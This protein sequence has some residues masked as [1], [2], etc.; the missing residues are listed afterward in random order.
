M[1]DGYEEKADKENGKKEEIRKAVP[2]T[3]A[4]EAGRRVVTPEASSR[5]TTEVE[6]GALGGA[7]YVIPGVKYQLQNSDGTF[8]NLSADYQ[9]KLGDANRL[10]V[11]PRTGDSPLPVSQ[12]YTGQ[13]RFSVGKKWS[14][15]EQNS[16]TTHSL[17]VEG[18]VGLQ[19]PMMPLGYTTGGE[20]G[21]SGQP[22]IGGGVGGFA[23]VENTNLETGATKGL[24]GGIMA[25]GGTQGVNI[26][27][28]IGAHASSAQI[29]PK[30]GRPLDNT[31][32]GNIN[33]F[34]GANGLNQGIGVTGTVQAGQ[35]FTTGPADDHRK[36]LLRESVSQAAALGGVT[37]PS[38]RTGASA[39]A[40]VTAKMNENGDTKN[41]GAQFT[42][43]RAQV[44]HAHLAAGTSLAHGRVSLERDVSGG[45]RKMT[46]K[47]RIATVGVYAEGFAA[48]VGPVAIP[49]TV[50]GG[51]TYTQANLDPYFTN[52]GRLGTKLGDGFAAE[53]GVLVAGGVPLPKV[54]FKFR[55]AS[56][57]GG[58][59]GTDYEKYGLLREQFQN[60]HANWR[61]YKTQEGK[62]YG[63]QMV[64]VAEEYAQKG[65]VTSWKSRMGDDQLEVQDWK[66]ESQT[67]ATMA[68]A[69]GKANPL[70]ADEIVRSPKY[71]NNANI[72]ALRAVYKKHPEY[73][74]P[75]EVAKTKIAGVSD[76]VKIAER[77]AD[78]K[79]NNGQ[80]YAAYYKAIGEY[81][82]NGKVAQDAKDY[83]GKKLSAVDGSGKQLAHAMAHTS[84]GS[85]KMAVNAFD[86]LRAGKITDAAFSKFYGKLDVKERARFDEVLGAS[87]EELK[88]GETK[89]AMEAENINGSIDKSRR[90]ALEERQK[91]F[92]VGQMSRSNATVL[93][94]K[95]PDGAAVAVMNSVLHN[96]GLL[97]K[98]SANWTS[99]SD[100]AL[101]K[102]VAKHKIQKG[103][104]KAFEKTMLA[105]VDNLSK[106]ADITTSKGVAENLSKSE[107]KAVADMLVANG[108]LAYKDVGKGFDAAYDKYVAGA[109]DEL[110]GKLSSEALSHKI[111]KDIGATVTS[112]PSKAAALEAK[113]KSS[114]VDLS[115]PAKFAQLCKNDPALAAQVQTAFG[116]NP[117]GKYGTISA[118]KRAEWLKGKEGQLANLKGN[119]K[120]A[121]IAK[122]AAADYGTALAKQT[123]VPQGI[124]FKDL[125]K[126][127]AADVKQ[128]TT[129]MGIAPTEKAS[130]SVKAA[131]FQTYDKNEPDH[132]KDTGFRMVA[133]QALATRVGSKTDLTHA[134]YDV[135]ID[136]VEK[137]GAITKEQ[138]NVYKE[139]AKV[140][141]AQAK[142]GKHQ[143]TGNDAALYAFA[144]ENGLI[145]NNKLKGYIE[146]GAQ[147][148]AGANVVDAANSIVTKASPFK[149]PTGQLNL[150]GY[151]A[152]RE[153]VVQQG[154]SQSRGAGAG[155][156]PRAQMLPG[157]T[158]K[159]GVTDHMTKI[160][161][162]VDKE[163]GNI[164]E[165]DRLDIKLPQSETNKMREW[166]QKH[167]PNLT[168]DVEISKVEQNVIPKPGNIVPTNGISAQYHVETISSK[169]E[170][171]H[172]GHKGGGQNFNQ[173]LLKQDSN[174]NPIR[175]QTDLTSNI[176][177]SLLVPVKQPDHP[178]NPQTPPTPPT[179][180]PVPLPSPPPIVTPI[181]PD[182][183]CNA[184]LPSP[185]NV[186]LPSPQPLGALGTDVQ[187]QINQLRKQVGD[188]NLKPVDEKPAQIKDAALA[189][190][191]SGSNVG[192][193]GQSASD[194]TK[195]QNG[196]PGKNG[197]QQMA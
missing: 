177:L 197:P 114:G 18:N 170:G 64:Q 43:V 144:Q 155:G 189:L 117:D 62:D 41:P 182:C 185:P 59:Q 7:F 32:S 140:D 175:E 124:D 160:Y 111:A 188:L 184:P 168:Q 105:S 157:N 153:V 57:R 146:S 96:E 148:K 15:I 12:A 49:L 20:P 9:W 190:Q 136:A 99:A 82:S 112:I 129:V 192:K 174:G 51:V 56:D 27:P 29:D 94:T 40:T 150:A 90:H 88:K 133:V 61:D 194:P 171:W 21:K 97:A 35:A 158:H 149:A 55:H 191:N 142:N 180:H 122:L 50:G 31:I 135:V 151:F 106:G 169:M 84:P 86:D 53:A 115:D 33:G 107:R 80:E 5:L 104:G 147:A 95:S 77:I 127:K 163:S 54:Q 70:I 92:E 38:I 73:L 48:T 162:H 130:M 113:L 30:T 91:Q 186:P 93:R 44:E 26:G 103:D 6:G 154:A 16:L 137:S 67:P 121:A 179:P 79:G 156:I 141:L 145:E 176:Q 116:A 46:H 36:V 76:K 109:K 74:N 89:L 72:L 159:P 52:E 187:N 193:S 119:E 34:V 87:R 164:V 183:G 8:A 13:L 65:K 17:S 1:A 132:N 63:L 75:E 85:L 128:L 22:Q 19:N 161:S 42:T 66:K 143:S 173:S 134:R 152:E 23:R 120:D 68:K 78:Y 100:L 125:S 58:L 195:I 110:K 181:P 83:S 165:S 11:V 14:E 172:E 4:P 126:A 3:A 24:V 108:S 102:Y 118:E 71:D 138:A 167:N 101:D 166:V 28:V 69:F 98:N 25:S 60:E 81:A 139:Q 10:Y 131:L 196:A 37:G 2:V 178:N 39:S 47:D 123:G 45:V